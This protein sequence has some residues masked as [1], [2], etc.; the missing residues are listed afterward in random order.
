MLYTSIKYFIF[1]SAKDI[2]AALNEIL[3]DNNLRNIEDFKTISKQISKNETI[4]S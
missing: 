2:Q 3:R 4:N 1:L